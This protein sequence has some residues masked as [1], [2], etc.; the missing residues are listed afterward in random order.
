MCSWMFVIHINCFFIIIFS[1][2]LFVCFFVLDLQW[3][4][5]IFLF[6]LG[7]SVWRGLLN[8]LVINSILSVWLFIGI[9]MTNVIFYFVG[10][11]GKVGYFPFLLLVLLVLYCSSYLFMFYDQ[12]IKWNYVFCFLL[13]NSIAISFDLVDYWL[14]LFQ[15]M[16]L[17]FSF[18]LIEE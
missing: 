3:I 9:L 16:F 5:L 18:Y 8:Y 10:C 13:I 14:I 2:S 12:I 11:F 7:N 17:L 1:S 4:T 15:F 6:V